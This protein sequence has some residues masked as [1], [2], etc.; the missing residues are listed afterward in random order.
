MAGVSRSELPRRAALGVVDTWRR[1][2]FEQRVAGIGA[3]LLIVSTFGPFSFVEAAIVLIGPAVLLLLRKRAEG[4]EFHIPFGDGT[5]I[6]AAGAWSGVLIAIRLFDRPLGQNLLALVCAGVLLIAGVAE[7]RK[8]P[9]DDLPGP[10]PEAH[11]R[12][13]DAVEWEEPTERLPRRGRRARA[14]G[15]TDVTAPLGKRA[16]ARRPE[17]CPHGGAG[18]G[19]R[20]PHRR[21]PRPQRRRTA[22][23]EAQLE[24]DPGAR[25]ARASCRRR[26]STMGDDRR[27]PERQSRRRARHRPAPPGEA[28]SQRHRAGDQQRDQAAP[29]AHDPPV[30][31]ERRQGDRHVH[32][33]AGHEHRP[34]QVARV[35]RADQDPVEGEDHA[36]RAAASA[37]TAAR[38]PARGRAPRGRR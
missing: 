21:A 1:L 31:V 9:P 3:L 37:R 23:C 4:R 26:S 33:H 11:Q 12:G 30:E 22:E 13:P 38:R 25:R 8:R 17:R 7:R 24:L 29:D 18:A 5:V 19:A 10:A 2:N 6:A 16:A 32:A 15:G 34:H 36:R 20:G 28:R 27:L 35:A 14:P